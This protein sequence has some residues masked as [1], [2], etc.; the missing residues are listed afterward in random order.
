MLNM[1]VASHLTYVF[2]VIAISSCYGQWRTAAFLEQYRIFFSTTNK[3][4][5]F[6]PHHLEDMVKKVVDGLRKRR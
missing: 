3:C 6:S 2:D 5:I 4:S 1:L